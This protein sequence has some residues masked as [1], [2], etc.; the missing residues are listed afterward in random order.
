MFD[1][2]KQKLPDVTLMDGNAPRVLVQ[3][4][5]VLAAAVFAFGMTFVLVKVIDKLFGGFCLEAAQ[6]SEGLDRAVHGEIGFDLGPTLEVPAEM[7]LAEPRP[8]KAPPTG[9]KR[10]TV[11]VE[12]GN[13]G[14]LMHTWSGLCQVGATPPSDDFRAV[15]PF[16]TTIQG[17]RFRFRGGNPDRISDSLKKLFE[18]RMSVPIRT[19]VEK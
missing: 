4:V 9:Q 7:P 1:P 6:E 8:A 2:E 15:Y 17:N 14:D 13:N 5:A 16:L 3:L 18:E 19:R 11:V 12:G 10:F